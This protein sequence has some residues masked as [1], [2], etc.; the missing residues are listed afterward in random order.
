MKIINNNLRI[1][2]LRGEFYDC[3]INFNNYTRLFINSFN[4]T[5][6]SKRKK[7]IKY[8]AKLSSID[9][10]FVR[11]SMYSKQCEYFS[12]VIQRLVTL[13]TF[14]VSFFQARITQHFTIARE[15]FMRKVTDEEFR[16]SSVMIGFADQSAVN[17]HS[18]NNH[19]N[20]S[21]AVILLRI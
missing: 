15:T 9:K 17:A 7:E 19:V 10:I 1:T 18:C 13:G 12:C 21:V 11:C 4:F 8:I 20:N 3:E 14:H 5:R 16:I 2:S 6:E